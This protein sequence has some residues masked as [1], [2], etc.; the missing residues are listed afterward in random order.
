MTPHLPPPPQAMAKKNGA[1]S[2]A[3]KPIPKKQPQKEPPKTTQE[4][5]TPPVNPPVTTQFARTPPSSP[6]ASS[7]SSAKRKNTPET[8]TPTRQHKDKKSA[9]T[10]PLVDPMEAPITHSSSVAPHRDYSTKNNTTH[11][12]RKILTPKW[13]NLKKGWKIPWFKKQKRS[14]NGMPL[15]KKNNITDLIERLTPYNNKITPYNGPGYRPNP[16]QGAQPPQRKQQPNTK[17]KQLKRKTIPKFIKKSNNTIILK[18]RSMQATPDDAPRHAP[19]PAAAPETDKNAT[20]TDD[21]D[22]G[23]EPEAGFLAATDNRFKLTAMITPCNEYI[24]DPKSDQPV[25]ASPMSGMFQHQFMAQL[26]T[27]LLEIT[28]GEVDLDGNTSYIEMEG[29]WKASPPWKATIILDEIHRHRV[30]LIADYYN[31]PQ[32]ALGPAYPER[33]LMEYKNNK[34]VI[35]NGKQ[36]WTGK[37]Q[38]P[39]FFYIF[40]AQPQANEPTIEY[41][42]QLRP[43]ARITF[44]QIIKE[45]E[46]RQPPNVPKISRDKRWNIQREPRATYSLA[47]D[48]SI[49]THGNNFTITIKKSDILTFTPAVDAATIN[50]IIPIYAWIQIKY[51]SLDPQCYPIKIACFNKEGPRYCFSGARI[52]HDPKAAD[53]EEAYFLPKEECLY[54]NK[55]VKGGTPC[56]DFSC[57]ELPPV[58][59]QEDPHGYHTWRHNHDCLHA[60]NSASWMADYIKPV[61][62]PPEPKKTAGLQETYVPEDT[63]TDWKTKAAAKMKQQQH[64]AKRPAPAPPENGGQQANKKPKWTPKHKAK[65][66]LPPSSLALQSSTNSSHHSPSVH[67]LEAIE[68]LELYF[69]NPSS[70]LGMRASSANAP[71]E[72]ENNTIER[73]SCSA[74]ITHLLNQ[75]LSRARRTLLPNPTVRTPRIPRNLVIRMNIRNIRNRIYQQQQ[76]HQPIGIKPSSLKPYAYVVITTKY[77]H[78]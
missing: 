77:N 31:S 62:Q 51:P 8:T 29:D 33:I 28:E 78:E 70:T 48:R 43:D 76:N 39:F 59:P 25:S 32:Q 9:T 49:K 2:A 40:E 58:T 53:S 18:L 55:Q 50:T 46:D 72:R 61:K 73:S 19:P 52:S 75:F 4:P 5:Q 42:M 13:K 57:M 35:K 17:M 71:S 68:L 66:P 15:T 37:A 56:L 30:P 3:N 34:S 47:I 23:Q 54:C 36:N 69:F 45:I 12:R 20:Q 10:T 65:S 44:S 7:G 21:T 27:N 64:K 1:A 41:S 26:Q 6:T 67:L 60:K 16:Q 24:H 22:H 11:D 63:P 74:P 14:K 38:I